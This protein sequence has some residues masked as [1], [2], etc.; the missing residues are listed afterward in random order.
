MKILYGVN[1]EYFG[2][3]LLCPD[4]TALKFL[5]HDKYLSAQQL[6]TILRT[7]ARITRKFPCQNP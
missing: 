7:G 6:L 3:N 4:S 2:D 5:K 1:C